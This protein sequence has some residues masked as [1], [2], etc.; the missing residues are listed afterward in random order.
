L[1]SA[2]RD[3]LKPT[4]QEVANSIDSE[5]LTVFNRRIRDRIPRLKLNLDD[6]D[7]FRLRLSGQPQPPEP[8]KSSHRLVND[9]FSEASK[10]IKN[11]VSGFNA[12]DQVNTLN[13]WV[14]FIE[15]RASVILLRVP[16]A[17]NAYRM[18]ETLN[19]RGKRTSQSDLVKNYLFGHAGD[20][21]SEVQQ[22]WACMRGA[23]ESMEDE[24]TTITFLRHSLTAIRGFVREAD[25][26]EVVQKHAKGEQPVITFSG[27]ME[28]LANDFVA[29]HN[30]DHERWNAYSGSTRRALDVLNLFD[31]NPMRPLLLSIAHKFSIRETQKA[32]EF[33]VSLGVRLMIASSTRTGTVEEGLAEAAHK[34][35]NENITTGKEL[36]THLKHLTPTD[37]RFRVAFET[38]TVS[39]RKLAR[40]Y[41][42]NYL[43]DVLGKRA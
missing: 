35:F 30:S 7:Y 16:N 22:K 29:I 24:D 21:I 27:Q 17:A 9:A 18:F 5:F 13:R 6:N 12:K 26:Y 3:Y 40:Y 10:H 1:L 28:V 4:E 32:L 25:V 31:I 36:T 15:T 11:V 37:G 38:A 20:R 41:I 2:I 34:I 23:L 14:D 33:C 19:D 8:T 39:N 42:G 43:V